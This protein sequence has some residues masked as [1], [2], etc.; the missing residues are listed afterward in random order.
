M[1]S[2]QK[3]AV[4]AL[5]KG[6][7]TSAQIASPIKF[8][9]ESHNISI[10]PLLNTVSAHLLI[11]LIPGALSL[12]RIP[13]SCCPHPL[14]DLLSDLDLHVCFSTDYLFPDLVMSCLT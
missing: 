7:K 10:S 9:N 2:T 8:L 1:P 11:C 12:N 14:C 13:V 6:Q 3:T 4:N 5:L